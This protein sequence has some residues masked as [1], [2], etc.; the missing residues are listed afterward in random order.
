MRGSAPKAACVGGSDETDLG[1]RQGAPADHRDRGAVR[2]L[3]GVRRRAAFDQPGAGARGHLGF[4]GRVDVCGGRCACLPGDGGVRGAG[5]PGRDGG[6]PRRCDR[7]Q[8]DDVDRRHDRGGVGLG[9]AG[10]YGLVLHRKEARQGVHPQAREQGADH[11]GALR[12][13]GG[14]LQPLRRS[15]DPDREIHRARA[16]AG[17]VHRG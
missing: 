10:G 3:P 12:A 2:R 13:G 11:A 1:V 14:L 6:G 17:A 16:G 8:R 5:V 4:A 7:G 15:D 9:V